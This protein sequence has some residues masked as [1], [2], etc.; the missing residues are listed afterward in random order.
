[1]VNVPFS[2][3]S[4]VAS[5]SSVAWASSPVPASR[6]A[7]VVLKAIR[8]GVLRSAT[9]ATR[10]TVGECGGGHL[11]GRGELARD[12]GRV[13]GVLG[14]DQAGGGPV[15]AGFEPGDRGVALAVAGRGEEDGGLG[16]ARGGARDVGEHL[17][18]DEEG[19]LDAIVGG[20]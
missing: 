10:L 13:L 16:G 5:V 19:S 20:L 12:E 11:R 4:S 3:P 15:A 9:R 14:G 17:R 8:T 7:C 2:Q 6:R 1:M 18:R